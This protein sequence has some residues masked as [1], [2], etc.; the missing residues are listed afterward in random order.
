M[1]TRSDR[2]R[3]TRRRFLTAT[4]AALASWPCSEQAEGYV[5]GL[6]QPKLAPYDDL[7]IKFMREHKPP[8]AALAVAYHGRLVYARGFGLADLEAR[9]AVEPLARFRIASVSKPFTATAV[10]QLVQ[11]GKLHLDE[12]VLPLLKLE[13]HLPWGARMDPRWQEI[14]VHHC[15]QH[16]GGWD[17]DKSFDPM[18]SGTAE[19]V[20]K[21]LH[22]PL[23]IHPRQII[24]YMLG[25]PLDFNPGTAFAYSNFG[26]C[27]L[28]R[29]IEAVAGKPYHEV[30]RERILAPLG[31]RGMQLGKNLLKD[32]APGEVKYYDSRHRT[33]RAICGPKIGAELPL[34][35]GVEG[36]ESMDANG[37]WIA[38]AVDLVRFAVALD[39]VKRS[40]LLN[41]ASIRSMF[42]P[43]P[44]SLG[45][46]PKGRPKPVYY[47]CGWEVRPGAQADKYTKW[48][49]GMISGTSTLLVCRNDGI[50][51]AVLFNS[52]AQKDGKQFAD[53][54][55]PL[56]HQPADQIKDW[57]EIDLF[58]RF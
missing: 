20:A 18:S 43:P 49:T 15:L 50:D 29:V 46:G 9:A 21:T 55:D 53:M 1:H 2:R 44:G 6:S 30:V 58:S 52:D 10:M 13:A 25:K 41:A 5:T 3:S 51:W 35:Y 8:G 57:P 38:S 7:M 17:R 42:A 36:I 27:V 4:V 45:H 28:G 34:P 14:T 32:R 40:P 37:G 12:R 54:I 39:D 47:G 16:I 24:S 33:G 22:V 19:Q 11:Q 56:L 31:I 48:H 26:Y 23:P